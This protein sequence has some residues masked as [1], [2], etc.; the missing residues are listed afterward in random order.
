[1]PYVSLSDRARYDK[2]IKAINQLPEIA[3]KGDLEF[4]VFKLMKKFMKD[5]EVR[6]STLHEAVYATQHSADEFRRR[7]LD[8]REDLALKTNGDIE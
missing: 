8:A 5:R 4:L 1:M 2:V 7:F 3:T 6:Y